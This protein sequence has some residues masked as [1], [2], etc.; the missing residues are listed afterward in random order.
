M[1]GGSTA[2]LRRVIFSSWRRSRSR[3]RCFSAPGLFFRGALKAGALAPRFR[4]PGRALGGDGLYPG[5][6]GGSFGAAPDVC[7]PPPGAGAARGA[8]GRPHARCCPTA[9]SPTHGASCAWMKPPVVE[10]RPERS[11]SGRERLFHRGHAGLVRRHRGASPARARFHGDG[12]GEHGFAA[13]LDHRRDDGEEAFP[14][15]GRARTASA[16]HPAAERRFA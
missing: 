3:S 13:G 16:L 14:E 7:R 1:S 2:F 9:T 5:P 8:G 10:G 11:G 4:S 12:S 6:R 15:R